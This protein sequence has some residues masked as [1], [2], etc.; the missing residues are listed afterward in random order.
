MRSVIAIILATCTATMTTATQLR[1]NPSVTI[2]IQQNNLDW[3]LAPI[4]VG[5]T[6]GSGTRGVVEVLTRMGVYMKPANKEVFNLCFHGN[7]CNP[8]EST[9]HR[10]GSSF[11]NACMKPEGKLRFFDG[12]PSTNTGATPAYM[13]W[14]SA[15]DCSSPISTTSL[16][17]SRG[18]KLFMESVPI[19]N[20]AQYRWGWKDPHSMY[21]LVKLFALYPHLIF[22]HALR[23]PLD[24]AADPW[25]H[26]KNRVIEFTSI[27][28]GYAEAAVKMRQRCRSFEPSPVK[29]SL[30]LKA[31]EFKGI[32]EC[33]KYILEC[34][35][36]VKRPQKG[37][38]RCL[39][40]MLWAE[41]NVGIHSFGSNCLRPTYRYVM[42]HSE[43]IYGLR[44]KL[45]QHNL[46]SALSG[47]LM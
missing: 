23:N 15:N 24:L 9:C 2:E 29:D 28:S 1:S 26:L 41:I 22:V 27:H 5:G 18:G 32:V 7:G 10:S 13:H 12:F 42:F 30:A 47:V 35:K 19:E 45:D 17:R 8:K 11:D 33:H 43:D 20:R 39:E 38:W 16:S 4:V 14:L 21:H 34:V 25:L 36:E 46:Q 44:G 31:S 37:P 6:G 3:K 40:L